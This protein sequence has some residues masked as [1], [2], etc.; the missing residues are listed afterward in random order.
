MEVS[1]DWTPGKEL[2]DAIDVLTQVA[3]ICHKKGINCILAIWDVP[4]HIRALIGYEIVD[5]ANKCNWDRHFKLA[6]V[7][8]HNERF[9]DSLFV[10][11][12]AVNRGYRVKMFENKQEAKSWLLNC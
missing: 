8:T 5:S 9:I 3:D 10:E 6:V 2:E 7:Y 4:G 1:G 11:T 12:V